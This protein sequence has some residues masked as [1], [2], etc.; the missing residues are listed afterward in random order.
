MGLSKRAVTRLVLAGLVLLLCV[1]VY[2]VLRLRRDQGWNTLIAAGQ[3]PPDART[4][5]LRFAWA[6][7]QAASGVTEAALD[8]YRTLQGESAL[9]QAARGLHIGGVVQQRQGLQRSIGARP[10]HGADL[11]RRSVE[12]EKRRWCGGALPDGIH[13]AAIETRAVIR[14]IIPQVAIPARLCLLYT[15]DAADE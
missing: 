13:R 15:S 1:T 9:G 14:L 3:A 8:R 4:P 12:E 5:E 7:A 6:H 10:L 11:A 2:D